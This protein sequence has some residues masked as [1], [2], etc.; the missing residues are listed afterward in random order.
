MAMVADRT[1]I[2]HGSRS[3]QCE[4]L[5]EPAYF[6]EGPFILAS[7]LEC[8]VYLLFCLKKEGK[9]DVYL[10]KLADPLELP[11][12]TRRQ[13]LERVVRVFADRLEKQCLAFPYQWYNFFDFWQKP[14]NNN[15]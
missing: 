1:S 13:D 9:Y 5:G 15:S 10:E 12:T 2:A 7:L 4:F 8:P 6:P 3:V 14:T 11:R